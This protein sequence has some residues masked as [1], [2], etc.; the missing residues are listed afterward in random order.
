MALTLATQVCAVEEGT[1][2]LEKATV[3][4]GD[5]QRPGLCDWESGEGALGQKIEEV[6]VRRKAQSPGVRRP[7]PPRA[8]GSSVG[9]AGQGDSGCGLAGAPWAPASYPTA[10]QAHV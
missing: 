2:S 9:S 4:G 7:L 1:G 10:P 5:A 3:S 6:G 8:V